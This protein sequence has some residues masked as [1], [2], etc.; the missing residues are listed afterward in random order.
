MVQK[1]KIHIIGGGLYGC[2]LAYHLLKK[3]YKVSIF[4]KSDE[5]VNSFDSIKLNKISLNNGFHGIDLP[6]SKAIFNFFKKNLKVNFDIFEIKRKIL[7]Q[8]N[9]I[10]YTAKKNEWPKKIRSY[11][12]K[13][14]KHYRNQKLNFFF[15]NKAINLFKLNSLRYFN[16]FEKAKSYFLPWFLPADIK[17]ISSDEGDKFRS[18]IR[19]KKIKGYVALPKSHVFE[20]IKKKMYKFLISKGAIVYFNTQ[21]KVSKNQIKYFN[22]DREI[23]FEK[24]KI[25]KTFYCLSSSFLIKDV[26]MSH[27]KKLNNYKRF[28]INCIIE[29]KDK[30]FDN[31]FSEILCLNKKIYF[32]NRIYSLNYYKY[33]KKKNSTYLII[34]ILSNKNSISNQNKKILINE[35]K[36]I[37]I[38]K[39]RPNFVDYKVTRQIYSVDN[40]WLD[41]SRKILRKEIKKSLNLSYMNNFYPLN[42]NKAWINAIN[43]SKFI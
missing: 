10:D 18:L 17:H 30:N 37:F 13:D 5:L 40:K 11:L 12:K 6:R 27:F 31:N 36:K 28:A 33:K 14:I 26:S 2:L 16:T 20:I 25:K 34:E 21:I 4:E 15:K 7:F 9:L 1:K 22:R 38:L 3:K 43:S 24:N 41:K 19:Q 23:F 32:S 8:D 39:I 42:M 35:I 29:I